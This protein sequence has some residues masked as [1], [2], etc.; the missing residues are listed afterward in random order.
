MPELA[1][2]CGVIKGSSGS[3]VLRRSSVFA[4]N[5]QPY[6]FP[7]GSPRPCALSPKGNHVGS[8][9]FQPTGPGTH[10]VPTPRGVERAASAPT[11]EQRM[12]RPFQ[13]RRI[14]GSDPTGSLRSPVATHVCPLAGT[15]E[16][17]HVLRACEKMS[18]T[19]NA[20][21]LPAWF[22]AIFQAIAGKMPALRCA[23]WISSQP[24]RCPLAGTETL[25]SFF[26]ESIWHSRSVPGSEMTIRSTQKPD[27]P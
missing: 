6:A 27:E 11:C 9:G 4:G 5:R 8:R 7:V 2:F 19:R 20:G 13:G 25:H 17:G 10:L 3:S 21:I 15:L 1:R 14:I 16:F 22:G 23:S 26:S 12:V 18:A 24:L